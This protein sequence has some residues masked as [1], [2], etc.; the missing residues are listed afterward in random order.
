MERK[1]IFKKMRTLLLMAIVL[2]MG[3]NL[4]AVEI[5]AFSLAANSTSTGG[6]AANSGTTMTISGITHSSYSGTNGQT[7]YG[8]NASGSD[9]WQ[10]TSFST[11]GYIQLTVQGQMKATSTGP[12]D[13]IGQYSLNGTSWTDIPNHLYFSDD[14]PLINLVTSPTAYALKSFK[15]RLP[16]ACDNKAT[17]YVR[18]VQNG[19]V[20]PDG[21]AIG[22]NSSAT[23]SLKGVSVQGEA[24]AAPTSQASIISI[25]SITPKTITVGCT[26]GSG[27][28]R[29]IVMNTSNSFTNPAN[30]DNPTSNTTY[31]SGEQVIY[32]GAG[33]QV[34]VTVP[35]ST[36]VY[37]FR[38][39]DYNIMDALTRFNVT[40][41]SGNPKECKLES[42]HSP[43]TLFGLTRATLGATIETPTTGT[44]SERGI[45]W[46][47]LPNVNT[48]GNQVVES[49]DQGGVFALSV[50]GGVDRGTTIYYKGYVTNESGTILT[51]EASFS[52]VPVFTGTGAWETAA[53]WNVGEVPGANG[54][55]TYGDVADSPIING[56]CTLGASNE[57][58]NLTIN[59]GKNLTISPE[60]KLQ[61]DGTLTNNA[62]TPGLVIKASSIAGTGNGSLV[63]ADPASNSSVPATVEMYSRASIN[64]SNPTGSKY[65]WQYFGIPVTTLALNPIFNSAYVRQWDESVTS[66]DDIWVQN[67]LGTSLLLSTGATLTPGNGYE[68]AQSGNK[69][70]SFTGTLVTSD[71][72]KTLSYTPSAYYKGQTVLSNPYVAG[73][74]ISQ[75]TFGANT[76]ASVYLYNTGTYND[77][78][79][80]NGESIPGSGPGTYTVSTPGS[81][82]VDGV[83]THIPSMQ[84][85][86]VKSTAIGGGSISLDYST[87][88]LISNTDAQKVKSSSTKISTM[89]D[90]IGTKFSDR[91]WIMD[92]INCTRSFDNGYD[93]PKSLGFAEVSQLY[94]S[95][96]D[97]IY[98]IDAVNDF[99][100]IYLGF[101]PGTETNFK[102]VFK[103]QNTGLKYS[104]IYL[105]DL[106]TNSTTDITQSGTEYQF[107]AASIDP[108]KRFKIITTITGLNNTIESSKLDVFNTNNTFIIH[109][110]TNSKGI[111]TIFDTMGKTLQV[112][113]F[114][115]KGLITIPTDLS[116][117]TYIIKAVVDS[118]KFTKCI[119]VN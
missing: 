22:T 99:N 79:S 102:L 62:S 78:L 89:I 7:C 42:I 85:F 81:V 34:T 46:S 105:V 55:A 84:G 39:Y 65:K 108:I 117:G 72:S 87:I 64:L 43:T 19:T 30:N 116:K 26:R 51:D 25:V 94:A 119:I 2:L 50:P 6:L 60:V 54:D 11:A 23:A 91:M 73:M 107:T 31:G 90:V 16:T 5:V 28:R 59:S 96:D 18:W 24:F 75:L 56:T 35:S 97:G 3:Q 100:N 83:P 104:K 44:I 77:W 14:E 86:I 49:T 106:V 8:W 71:F 80:S 47:L 98:Q 110:T 29:I 95:E 69:T 93:G 66:Y 74:D 13:F 21:G 70:Y 57:V 82:G 114:N 41:A 115:S 15:F 48:G 12:R 101:Q 103:H 40:T 113:D 63:F 32:N 68:L 76:E 88:N 4:W 10:T 1:K 27:N 61:V 111:L 9:R 58:T 45:F 53:R 67:N 37:W 52:N 17:V 118:E 20:N 92:D 38:Y 112:L 33:D 36:N 109:N